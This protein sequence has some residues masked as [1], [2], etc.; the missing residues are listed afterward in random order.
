MSQSQ[1]DCTIPL[2]RGRVMSKPSETLFELRSANRKAQ[3]AW[4]LV[5]LLAATVAAV[6]LYREPSTPH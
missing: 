6:G 5:A 1:S 3:L 4:F 2:N